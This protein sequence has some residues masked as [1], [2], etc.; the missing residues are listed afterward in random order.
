[1]RSLLCLGWLVGFGVL[2]L[3][4]SATPVKSLDFSIHE[5]YVST[6]ALGMGNAFTAGA[7]D[8]SAL[9]Y[10]FEVRIDSKFKFC[11]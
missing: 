2:G 7:D 4:A 9:F 1:M 8:F 5:E 3:E 10:N 11:R 6:R